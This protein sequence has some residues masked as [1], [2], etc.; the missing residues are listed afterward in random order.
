MRRAARLARRRSSSRRRSLPASCAQ[1]AAGGRSRG[2]DDLKAEQRRLQETQRQLSEERAKAAEA[3]EARDV[4]AGG[5]RDDRQGAG[6]EEAARSRGSTRA[7]SGRRRELKAL[8]GDIGRLA[9]RRSEQ[10]EQLVRRLRALY[11]VQAQG[12]AASRAPRRRRSGARARRRSAR[13]R[14]WP[15][16]DA[17]LIEEYRVDVRPARRTASAGRRR[18]RPSSRP[19][20]RT[21]SASRSRST[22]RPRKRRALLARVRDERAYHE[23]MV[24]E[25]TRG[26]QAPRDLR[27]RAPGEAAAARQGAAARSP[28]DRAARRRGS[29]RCGAGCRGRPTARSS[30]PSAPRCIRASARGRSG[31][32]ST[33]RRPRAPRWGRCIAGHVDLHGLVQGVRQPD[34]PRPRQRLLHAL[35]PRRGHPGQGRGR[36]P[37]GPADRHGGGHRLADGTA[38]LFRGTLSGQAS[39]PGAMAAPAAGLGRRTRGIR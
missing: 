12:G 3:Q 32:A 1:R 24:G 25:L 18:G 39:G 2:S 29:A 4:A 35:R 13:S 27:P 38:A 15:P 11:K 21:P 17:R 28:G 7:S 5:A 34:H 22:A 10:E 6:R 36:R 30:R 37:P 8:R 26:G 14:T 9:G 20:A 19:C 31:T 33:S 23:R 16:L